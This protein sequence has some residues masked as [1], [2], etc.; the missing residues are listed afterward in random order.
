MLKGNVRK[1]RHHSGD[2]DI[3]GL[4]AAARASPTFTRLSQKLMLSIKICFIRFKRRSFMTVFTRKLESPS[5]TKRKFVKAQNLPILE[6]SVSLCD[7]LKQIGERRAFI[8]PVA[9]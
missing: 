4:F 8:K 6:G 5:H 9:Q 2:P 1:T 7:Y 3:G